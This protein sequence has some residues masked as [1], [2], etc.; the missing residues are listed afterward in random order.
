MRVYM[1]TLEVVKRIDSRYY[2]SSSV[3]IDQNNNNASH[4]IEINNTQQ[5]Y[6]LHIAF[7]DRSTVQHK[8]GT[9]TDKIMYYT[10]MTWHVLCCDVFQLSFKWCVTTLSRTNCSWYRNKR[11]ITAKIVLSMKKF[12][13]NK[14]LVAKSETHSEANYSQSCKTE[15]SVYHTPLLLDLE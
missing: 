1:Y 8:E 14:L 13:L 15:Y 6:T 2:S 12:A 9:G 11:H 7:D 5:L 10:A 3:S 4:P